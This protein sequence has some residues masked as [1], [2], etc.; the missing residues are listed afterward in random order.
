MELYCVYEPAT[1][2]GGEEAEEVEVEVEVKEEIV[3]G[4]SSTSSIV[5]SRVAAVKK[6]SSSRSTRYL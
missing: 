2:I 5:S 6:T 3:W 1:S 4:A